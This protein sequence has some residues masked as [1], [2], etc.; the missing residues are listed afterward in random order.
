[1]VIQHNLLAMNTSDVMQT[2][3]KKLDK[4]TERLSSGYKI[5]RS[6]DDAAGLS[7]SEK[8][9][10][11]I[12]GLNR[13]A[14][15]ITD[16]ISYCNV[17]EG[18]LSEIHSMLDRIKEL[19]VQAANDTNTDSDREALNAEVHQLTDEIDDIFK[20]TTFNTKKIW[21][22]SYIPTTKGNATDFSLYNTTD[23]DGTYIGG[24]QYM[25][26][27][28]SWEDIGIDYDRQTQTFISDG[29]YTIDGR[30]LKNDSATNIDDQGVNASFEIKTVKGAGLNTAQKTYSW[31]ADNQGITIDGIRTNG[32][33]GS[34]CGNTSWAAMG[35]TAGADVPEGTYTFKYYGMEISFSV[36]DG[37]SD[38]TSFIDG[39]NNQLVHIDWH[40]SYNGVT[41]RQSADITDFINT[42]VTVN[43]S[44]KDKISTNGYS[45]D[46][47]ENGLSFV[48]DNNQKT[49]ISWKDVSDTT[50]NKSSINSW[51]AGA[52]G[53]DK[54]TVNKD[55]VYE[56]D[57][58]YMGGFIDYK[59]KLNQDGSP[60][61][62]TKDLKQTTVSANTYSPTTVTVKSDSSNK[63]TATGV[64]SVV[65]FNT[66]R[67]AFS[68]LF[69]QNDENIASGT[70]ERSDSDLLNTSN[71][72]ITFGS[73]A[74]TFVCDKD[75]QNTFI[76]D[77]LDRK[78]SIESYYAKQI[79]P[80]TGKV[81]DPPLLPP[82]KDSLGLGNYNYTFY[83]KAKDNG[84]GENNYIQVGY[85]LS[86]LTYGDIKSLS[87]DINDND[88]IY[89]YVSG[90]LS[91]NNEITLK[92]D[93]E[94]YQNLQV[95]QADVVEA[96]VK[97]TA[98]I[99]GFEVS[100]DIQSGAM[101]QQIVNISY[102]YMRADNIGIGGLSLMT[103][104]DASSAISKV[105]EAIDKVSEQRSLFGA[106]TNRLEHA[107]NVNKNTSENTQSA[108]SKIR[109]TDMEDEMVE[110]SKNNIV[111]QVGQSMLAQANQIEQQVLTLL[112]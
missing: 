80:S 42:K 55:S 112:Q 12:R 75:I 52:G 94:T 91:Q 43:G 37:G 9:R 77:I 6:A 87:S 57:D 74:T 5:N 23:A 93:G 49:T 83:N 105:D 81:Y 1:M 66:Q 67:D 73:D 32:A 29:S 24:I 76:R 78:N 60:E 46:A 101:S 11:Q 19:S 103:H 61:S 95:R 47:D 97:N 70:I 98:Q 7:I 99:D 96:S 62:I 58:S 104:A 16:G 39:I 41:T 40:S 21:C 20:N 34:E 4:S 109:D 22:A 89:N 106:Y 17:A 56:F 28:Y 13:A 108:E 25:N 85:N 26:H 38:W 100:L 102:D 72:K 15:N 53:S 111:S 14:D 36:P 82:D 54:I 68:R 45:V 18:A 35:I 90:L 44:N 110:Y 3:R 64:N 86:K 8:M 51:G 59:F 31:K 63:I 107:Y 79:D 10:W 92:G 71:Y 30:I 33:A 65:G 50:A 48:Y 27:R 69:A 2:I 84:L 88:N